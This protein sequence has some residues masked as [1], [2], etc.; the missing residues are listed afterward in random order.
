MT[1]SIIKAARHAGLGQTGLWELAKLLN[2][3]PGQYGI[4]RPTLSENEMEEVALAAQKAG[5][6][7]HLII[8][9]TEETSSRT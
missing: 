7:D 1:S 6:P 4:K 2:V 9:I 3:E 8:M 5:I